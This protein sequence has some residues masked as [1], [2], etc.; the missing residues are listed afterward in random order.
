MKRVGIGAG[1]LAT[2]GAV[3][4]IAVGGGGGDSNEGGSESESDPTTTSVSVEALP[5]QQVART[6]TNAGLNLSVDYPATWQLTTSNSDTHIAVR[7]PGT[8]TVFL[9]GMEQSRG[10]QGPPRT[11]ATRLAADPGGDYGQITVTEVLTPVGDL[12]PFRLDVLRGPTAER[13]TL[14]IQTF[15]TGDV[16]YSKWWMI[17]GNDSTTTPTVEAMAQTIT[18]DQN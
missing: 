14:V 3:W 18:I 15:T 12:A 10:P 8:G 9:T 6:T 16:T 13:G 4:F 2:A 7:D 11:L 1:V 5:L 17:L